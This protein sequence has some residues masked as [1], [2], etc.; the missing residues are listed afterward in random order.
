MS[1][2]QKMLN[3]MFERDRKERERYMFSLGDFI[4]ALEKAPKDSLVRLSTSTHNEPRE[5][6]SDFISYRGY[7]SD[8]ALEPW[9]GAVS[10]K[11]LLDAAN[12]AC[13]ETFEG[14]KGGDF[15]MTA[16]TPLWISHYGS[17]NNIAV[18]YVE[19]NGSEVVIVT[20]QVKDY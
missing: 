11:A 2:I 20:F 15:T 19:V 6:T 1:D 13:G 3:E 14:Y 7:Y 10:V 9:D 8:I 5:F 12:A 17:A 16:D 4:E 18:R